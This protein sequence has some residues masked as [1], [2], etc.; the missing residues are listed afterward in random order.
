[1]YYFDLEGSWIRLILPVFSETIPSA[2]ILRTN[3]LKIKVVKIFLSSITVI[4]ISSENSP[5]VPHPSFRVWA[6]V[7]CCSILYK[8]IKSN[9][10]RLVSSLY[11]N[12]QVRFLVLVQSLYK[13]VRGTFGNIFRKNLKRPMKKPWC[14]LF[15]KILLITYL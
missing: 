1:M 3:L 14:P 11:L 9:I 13:D 2:W 10:S 5:T 4:I 8:L 6:P 15:I 7:L 12:L